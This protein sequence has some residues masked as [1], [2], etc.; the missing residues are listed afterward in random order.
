MRH[1]ELWR[2][3]KFVAG[4]RGLRASRARGDV[5][6]RSL[7]VADLL[8]PV[9]DRALERHASGRLV[10][11][12]CGEIPLFGRYRSLVDEAI[13]LDR[14]PGTA[15]SRRH[16]DLF[17]DLGAGI[18]LRTD[19]VDTL[20]VTDVLE[21]LE[22]PS[23]LWRE[24]ARV[25]RAGGRLVVGVPFLYRIH[26]APHDYHRYTRYRLESFCAE[27]GFEPISLEPYG[28]P[29]AVL[30]DLVVKNLPGRRLPRAC[31]VLAAAFLRSWAGRRLDLR[32][33]ELFPLGY[34]LVAERMGP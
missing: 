4:R 5:A 32:H 20:L 7:L 14:F 13:C 24:A 21:H 6:I 31:Q 9:Y 1:A 26:E 23:T 19:S 2:E 29:V 3:T 22:T 18:P 17:A 34:T 30:C 25:L 10:D 12:G 28:G 11:L 33:R 8:A 16:L 27:H 15:T